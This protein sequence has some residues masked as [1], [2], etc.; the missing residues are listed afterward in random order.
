MNNYSYCIF[1]APSF[2]QFRQTSFETY[3][4]EYT[5]NIV[6]TTV[7]FVDYPATSY[8]IDVVN[9]TRYSIRVA[10]NNSAGLGEYSSPPLIIVAVGV[11]KSY[12]VL[13][14]NFIDTVLC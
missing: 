12:Y 6:N 11:G 10:L 14:Q 8:T 5:A 3:S 13:S 2:N 1:Q 7:E 4:I 9:N